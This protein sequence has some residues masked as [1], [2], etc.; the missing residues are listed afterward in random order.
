MPEQPSSSSSL[1]IKSEKDGGDEKGFVG[2]SEIGEYDLKEKLGEGTFGVVWKGIRKN[3]DRG[4]V[5]KGQVVALKEILVHNESDGM[6]ITSLREIRILKALDHPNVVPCVDIAF[7]IGDAQKFILGKTFMVFPYMDHDLTGL[8]ENPS[9]RLSDPVIKQY[10]KQLL[11]GT[12]YL[13]QNKILH[14][15]M[16]AAN[17]LINNEGVL[18]IADFGLARSIH[19]ASL[20]REYTNFV[21]TRW[22]RP[23]ELLL[24]ERKYHNAVD[25][26]GVGCVIMEMYKKT[27]YFPGTSDTDQADKIFAICGSPDEISM[28]GF[29]KLPGIEERKIWTRRGRILK[30]ECNLMGGEV[31][32]D[33]M[34]KILRLD[35]K[36]RL[37]AA[38]ALDHEW[39][40]SEPLPADPKT[41]P[42]Y[43][44]SHEFDKRKR[45]EAAFGQ[46]QH[47]PLP[48]AAPAPMYIPPNGGRQGPPPFQNQQQ[49]QQQYQQGGNQGGPGWYPNQQQQQL[50][51][52][53]PPF[54]GNGQFQRQQGF[55]H[56]PNINM[57]NN[58]NNNHNQHRGGRPFN[59]GGHQ[60]QPPSAAPKLNL[61]QLAAASRNAGG[62]QQGPGG[63]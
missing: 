1:K 23:P 9:V 22:Y 18:M 14:R 21:V 42:T 49:Q 57:N 56:H 8:L 48:V 20:G 28:P 6:P 16:K 30:H 54:G 33:L 62:S 32:A 60:N 45:E 31:F 5:K 2:A 41:M 12:A 4:R 44:S 37:T 55:N 63:R 43:A 51:Q 38:Q 61:A 10:S 34:D 19:R 29:G 47:R 24:G 13:H 46:A 36:A 17:L 39:F 40:W 52:N 15:D 11:Q 26:W 7:Q 59:R 53:G 50:Q 27:P 3:D 58:L 25:M 35:P